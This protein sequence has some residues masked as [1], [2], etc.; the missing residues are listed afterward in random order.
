MPE[1]MSPMARFHLDQAR[2][3]LAAVRGERGDDASDD[4]HETT[5]ESEAR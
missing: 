5:T 1:G 3:A 2:R 4:D